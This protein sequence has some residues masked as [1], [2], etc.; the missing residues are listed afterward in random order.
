MNAKSRRILF[1]IAMLIWGGV[2]LYFYASGRIAKYLA[3]DF[4]TIALLGGLGLGVVGLFNLLT[5]G[6]TADCGHDHGGEEH[7]HE[8]GDMH[9]M[10]AFVLMVAPLALSVA[11]TKDSFTGAALARKG[12]YDAPSQT[13]T[14]FLD[15]TLG[16][17]TRESMEEN[18]H[19]TT[20]GFYQ[21]SL[22]ELFYSTGDRELQSAIDGM[23]VETEG[24][25]AF[26]KVRDEGGT[27][28][29]IYRLFMTCCI[30]DSR[31]VPIV[32][33]FGKT[34][35]DFPEEEWVKVIGK[36]TYSSED[37]IL[38]PVLEVEQALAAEPPFEE[39]F[40]RN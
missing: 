33:E 1:S 8:T 39:T 11:W 10:L 28:A 16:P 35:P 24:R 9:P 29:R 15:E 30:A 12:L 40:M 6:Q 26:E 38:Q 14:T 37:G 32:L 3:E 5:A 18:H 34:P 13:S 23:P 36:M 21:F 22:M 25:W 4:R 7:D 2:I 17:I 20:D 31:A 27:R 19:K